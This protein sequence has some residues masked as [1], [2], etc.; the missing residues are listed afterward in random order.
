[1]RMLHS[2]ATGKKQAYVNLSPKAIR[3]FPRCMAFVS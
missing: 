1:M 2:V 3:A